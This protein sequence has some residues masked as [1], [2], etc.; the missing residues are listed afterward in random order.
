MKIVTSIRK[1]QE[2]SRQTRG[3]GLV[4]GFV[5]TMGFLHEG[6]LELVRRAR[7]LADVVVVSIF[8]NPTQFDRAD[9]FENYPRDEMADRAM[10]E[11]EGV[12]FLFA[13]EAADVYAPDASTKV[14]VAGLTSGLCGAHRPGHFEGVATVVASL[15]NMVQPDLAVFGEKDYQQLAVVRRMVRD[16]HLPVQIVGAPIVREPDGLAMSSRNARLSEAERLVAPRLQA[17]LAAAARAFCDEGVRET[18]ALLDRARAVY[19]A[20]PVLDIE[21]LEV[22]DGSSLEPRAEADETSVLAVA[23]FLGAVRLIDNI[24][25]ERFGAEERSFRLADGEAADRTNE[26]VSR[27]A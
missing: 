27:H 5:P 7:A 19:A 14:S 6:H 12:N 13:P 4:V 22:I 3:A 23:A 20:A 24:V 16:L 9:D 18:S 25:L 15:L 10:L 2:L 11:H 26:G 1:M 17:G 8:V 21:Y